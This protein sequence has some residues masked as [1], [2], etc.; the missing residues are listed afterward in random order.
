[1]RLYQIHLWADWPSKLCCLAHFGDRHF[2]SKSIICFHQIKS[3]NGSFN[4]STILVT[5]P[6][7]QQNYL[8][9]RI[10][11]AFQLTD[12]KSVSKHPECLTFPNLKL[13]FIQKS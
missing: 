3:T 5:F 10:Y 7:I 9:E 2:L 12:S 4:M 6:N 13:V 11:E 1:M 8:T